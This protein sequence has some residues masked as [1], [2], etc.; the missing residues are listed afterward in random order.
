MIAICRT[1]I[2]RVPGVVLFLLLGMSARPATATFHFMHIDLVIGGVNGDVT[3]Q[4]VQMRTRFH[5]QNLVD[6]GRLVV[7]DARGENPIIIADFVAPVPNDQQGAAILVASSAFRHYTSPMVVPDFT[8]THLI[9]ASYLAAGTLTFETDDG[10]FIVCRLTWGG[11]AYIGPTTGSQTND[12]DGEF[13]P[14]VNGLLPST[15]VHALRFTGDV[16]RLSTTNLA[17][18]ELTSEA[19]VFSSNNGTSFTVTVFDCSDPEADVDADG[20]CA[21]IDNCPT[22]A[23]ADQRDEDHDGYGDACDE[24]PLDP[25]KNSP[26]VCGCGFSDV[27][28]NTDGVADCQPAG[29]L[30]SD[31][32]HED[33][34]DPG[35][36]SDGSGGG[37]T[38][39]NGD[40]HT[41][42]EHPDPA[43]PIDD[44][45]NPSNGSDD[46]GTGEGGGTGGTDS[47]D[48]PTH[49][50]TTNSA[51]RGGFCGAGLLPVLPA[52]ALTLSLARLRARTTNE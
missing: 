20:I 32:G 48:N 24:C 34:S 42:P 11:A 40:G 8:M 14:P 3:A 52:L 15:G 33:H 2:R 30:P 17:D 31:G 45:E 22:V 16:T 44:G 5:A 6:R 19:A 37:D 51:P 10:T 25:A 1:S 47:G 12:N 35:N 21:T 38:S 50:D 36:T 28:A 4:A 7:R 49:T 27:D 23:N 18:F 41:D 39:D 29:T 26:G 43:G 9:P 13:G 46:H